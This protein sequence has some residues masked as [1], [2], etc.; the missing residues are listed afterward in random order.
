MSVAIHSSLS[1]AGFPPPNVAVHWSFS[2]SHSVLVFVF[3]SFSIHHDT[4]PVDD[5]RIV[6]I[7][8]ALLISSSTS[9]TPPGFATNST[10]TP[11]AR[12]WSGPKHQ[13]SLVATLTIVISD[14]SRLN[15]WTVAVSCCSA[16]SA[17]A[18][19]LSNLGRALAQAKPSPTSD[20]P[21]QQG[22]LPA[23][24][25]CRA[26]LD[27][28]PA[29]SLRRQQRTNSPAAAQCRMF[30]GPSDIRTVQPRF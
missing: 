3:G 21:R 11:V 17:R 8:I 13:I 28:I 29:S 1:G 14:T 22:L 15:S 25:P 24:A 5:Q 18:S 26:S 23:P 7:C 2:L 12:S 10:R 6:I 20:L 16:N 27:L 30:H 9:E 4:T 19:L